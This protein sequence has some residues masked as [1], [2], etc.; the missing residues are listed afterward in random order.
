M[1]RPLFVI[2]LVTGCASLCV[3]ASASGQAQNN[4][5]SLPTPDPVVARIYDEGMHNSQ[6]ASLAQ[7]LTDSIGPRLTGST[8]NRAANDWLLR[9]YTAWGIPA[10]KEQYGT[11][12]DWTRGVSQVELVSPRNRVLEATMLAWSATT[13]PGGVTG[14][15]VLLPPASEVR[16]S[17]GFARWLTTV[18]GKFVAVSFPQPTC[19]TDSAWAAWASPESYAAMRAAR[20][21][22]EAEWNRRI[23]VAGR[24][25]GSLGGRIART[26]VAGILVS[27]WS[28]GWGV[29]KIQSAGERDAPAFDVSCEDYGL[30]ARLA[31]NG[32]HPRVRAVAE[33]RLA[34][35]ES[36]VYNTIAELKGSEHPDQYVLLSAHVDSWDAGSGATDNGTG[37]IV[38]LEAMRLLKLAY[39]HPK[40]TIIVGHWSGEEEGEIGST[41]FATDHP[42]VLKGLQASFTQD[43]GTGNIDTIDTEGFLDAP[44]AF[45]RW[46]SR[47]P[48]ELTHG[49]TID[50]PGYAWNEDSDSDAFSCRDAPGFFLTS[51]DW[52]YND[53][54]W[55]T[56]RDTYD[57][58]SFDEVKRN[59]TLV[60]LLAYEASEDP[61]QLSRARRVPPTDPKTGKTVEPPKCSPGP[62]SWAAL[63]AGH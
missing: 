30:L 40:R 48:L 9:T 6:T 14:D 20:D 2:S 8:A 33:A 56:N 7:V 35:T 59:A 57:K 16:D 15:V 1:G 61:V 44:A 19:R 54:T 38:M 55:H 13:P 31:A 39:P 26:G 37:T 46:M 27:R 28:L 12:L 63:V 45:G 29:D 10:R 53:Y 24:A 42:E 34:P 22:G 25:G 49:I 4:P 58:I 11:W 23:A 62:R 3:A 51:A 47:L 36:P 41:S 17:A 5:K 32:Q 18:A 50:L 21:S 60:A 52:N 43:N